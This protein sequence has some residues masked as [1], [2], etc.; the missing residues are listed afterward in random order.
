LL[1]RAGVAGRRLRGLGGQHG[2]HVLGLARSAR[3]CRRGFAA[4]SGFPAV[5]G[6]LG[7]EKRNH[8]PD[9]AGHLLSRGRAGLGASYGRRSFASLFHAGGLAGARPSRRGRSLVL[10]DF[11]RSS[12]RRIGAAHHLPA[13]VFLQLIAALAARTLN[14]DV[15]DSDPA[16]KGESLDANSVSYDRLGRFE[17]PKLSGGASKTRRMIVRGLTSLRSG[18][19]IRAGHAFS[20]ARLLFETRHHGS[21]HHPVAQLFVIQAVR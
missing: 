2:S 6:L 5:V 17:T 14:E 1:P 4:L 13:Q 10:A 3:R 20:G 11:E 18:R 19:M 21:A 8:I 9:R 16:T 15:H 12:A 7:V